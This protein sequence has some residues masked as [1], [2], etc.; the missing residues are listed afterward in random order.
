M[1]IDVSELGQLDD[2]AERALQASRRLAQ[3]R[4]MSDEL[5]RIRREALE[6]LIAS[7]RTQADLA[8]MLGMTRARVGQLLSAGPKSE[9]A[10]L[11]SGLLTIAIGGKREANKRGSGRVLAQEDLAA[12]NQIKELAQ[13]LG[14]NAEHEI[15][16]PPGFINLNREN[17]VVICGPRLSPLIGQI[18][19]SDRN[20]GFEQD[21]QGW[22]L[23]DRSMGVVHRSP[24]DSGE[25]RDY[26]YVGRLPRIDGRGTF[27]YIAGI[28]AVGAP[29]AVHYIENH[30]SELYSEV[31][32]KRFSML[33]ACD[34]DPETLKVTD[35]RRLSP[36]YRPEGG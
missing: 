11:G 26:A 9:R 12:F 8:G 5:S 34:F 1:E 20:L 2:P 4:A 35:S 7:G 24:M 19:E 23:V 31:K 21:S 30:L 14:L 22:Y 29:G 33:V 6:E 15:V 27:L 28:H 13:T 32:V 18:L 10:F 25:S 17:L 36:I 3:Y 16:E